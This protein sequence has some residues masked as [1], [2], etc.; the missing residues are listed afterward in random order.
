V[1]EEQ[2]KQFRNLILAGEEANAKF[3]FDVNDVETARH[4]TY[5]QHSDGTR[6]TLTPNLTEWI[7]RAHESLDLLKAAYAR[8]KFLESK[9]DR[10]E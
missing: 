8:I 7:K 1:T 6:R 2:M 4:V 9:D 3:S 5:I 10:N